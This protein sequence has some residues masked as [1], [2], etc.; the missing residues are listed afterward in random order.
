MVAGTEP[1]DCAVP[2]PLALG[3]AVAVRV[4]APALRLSNVTVVFHGGC[5]GRTSNLESPTVVPEVTTALMLCAAAGISLPETAGQS[6]ATASRPPPPMPAAPPEP[7][8]PV[9]IITTPATTTAST[10]K[11]ANCFHMDSP[12]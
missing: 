7:P 10:A 11:Y 9:R 12:L 8:H 6:T 1:V 5:E 4:T 3:Y 2:V